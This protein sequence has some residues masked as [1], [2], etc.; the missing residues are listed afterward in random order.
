MQR[1]ALASLFFGSVVVRVVCMIGLAA[2]TCR[3]I[4]LHHFCTS[5]VVRVMYNMVVGLAAGAF[6]DMRLHHLFASFAVLVVC[7]V[8]L[9]AGA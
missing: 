9:A 3:D 7:M 2:G 5:V 4:S 1:H 6:R 8:G